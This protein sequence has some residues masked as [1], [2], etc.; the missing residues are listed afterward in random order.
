MAPHA[1]ETIL[2]NEAIVADETDD[3]VVANSVG[4]P[5]KRLYVGISELA[6]QSCI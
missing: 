5:T 6:A 3:S 4:G 2:V 1:V